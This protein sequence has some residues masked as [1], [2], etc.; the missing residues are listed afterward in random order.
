MISSSSVD[1]ARLWLYICNLNLSLRQVIWIHQLNSNNWQANQ[2]QNDGNCMGVLTSDILSCSPC[3]L[4]WRSRVFPFRRVKPISIPFPLSPFVSPFPLPFLQFPLFVLFVLPFY[5]TLR[6]LRLHII[7]HVMPYVCRPMYVCMVIYVR[8][9]AYSLDCHVGAMINRTFYRT[10]QSLVVH[11]T[12][13]VTPT[14]RELS[15]AM[16]SIELG[17]SMRSFAVH[18]S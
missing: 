3:L 2:L 6:H 7:S 12:A 5:F 10:F 16:S 13:A 8:A 4:Q 9:T 18:S 1:V 14:G 15:V 11:R 17:Q